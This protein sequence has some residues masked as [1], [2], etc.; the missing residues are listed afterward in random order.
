[1]HYDTIID[2]I[3]YI[4]TEDF[5]IKRLNKMMYKLDWPPTLLG[6]DCTPSYLVFAS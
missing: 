3:T 4:Y 1:M 6:V 2:V 5:L